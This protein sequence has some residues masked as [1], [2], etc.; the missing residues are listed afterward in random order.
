MNNLILETKRRRKV[1]ND[2]NIENNIVPTTINKSIDEIMLSTSVAGSSKE[3]EIILKDQNFEDMTLQ[4]R[5]NILLEL[6][7]A[8][9]NSAENLDFEKAARLRDEINSFENNMKVG[10]K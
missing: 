2:Y 8:M 6:R 1:Q 7:K 3:D 9:I 5:E 10:A 4:D